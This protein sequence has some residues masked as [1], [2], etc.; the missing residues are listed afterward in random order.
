[1]S[2][3]KVA[4]RVRPFNSRELAREAE[5]IITMEG[6]TTSKGPKSIP[7]SS[8]SQPLLSSTI[9]TRTIFVPIIFTIL[10]TIA[11]FLP[12]IKNPKA[13]NASDAIKSFNFDYSYWSK[14]VS[15]N[16]C[17]K[18]VYRFLISWQLSVV[19]GVLVLCLRSA[20]LL[21]Y[22]VLILCTHS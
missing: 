2:G 21:Y 10:I 8:S 3:V 12:G 7:S 11:M 18:S 6:A 13:G 20:Y 15:A 5:S 14:E 9:S 4:V 1:M 19:L 16:H 22:I 17:Q